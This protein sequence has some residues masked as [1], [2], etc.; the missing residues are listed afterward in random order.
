MKEPLQKLR[1]LDKESLGASSLI[2]TLSGITF[3]SILG[4]FAKRVDYAMRVKKTNGMCLPDQRGTY[5]RRKNDHKINEVKKFLDSFPHF[6]SHYTSTENLY[7][8]TELNKTTM[9]KL[10]REKITED[11]IGEKQFMTILKSNK[12]KFITPRQDTCRRCDELNIKLKDA[13]EEEK[14][15]LI[16]ER[17]KHHEEAQA[18]RDLLSSAS[19]EARLDNEILVFT[20]DLEKTQPLPFIQTSVAFYKRQLW[21]YNLGVNTR[22]D[23]QGHMFLWLENEGRRGSEEICSTIFH[24]LNERSKSGVAEPKRMH[25]FSDCCGGQNRNK[26]FVFF[27]LWYCNQNNNVLEWQHSYLEP[28][29]TFLPNDRD[30]GMIERKK[31]NSGNLYSINDWMSVIEKIHSISQG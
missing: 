22:H 25:S 6:Q 14:Q 28:G 23:N 1:K 16:H 30:F 21:L 3:C 24:F 5:K 26:Y 20:F 8:S 15:N 4:I 27:M 10:Y 13:T 12:I 9:Y 19:T 2:A 17:E 29:H 11:P 31:K 18:A 7:F